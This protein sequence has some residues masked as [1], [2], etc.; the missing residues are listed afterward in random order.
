[1]VN[2]NSRATG[3]FVIKFAMSQFNIRLAVILTVAPEPGGGGQGQLPRSSLEAAW[4]PLFCLVSV[5]TEF[6]TEAELSEGKTV[7]SQFADK[8]SPKPDEL[9]KIKMRVG[10]GKA[11]REQKTFCSCMT[12]S[13]TKS[14][15]CQH[16]W[17]L[18]PTVSHPW[19]RLN[20]VK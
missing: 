16:S 17:L 4:E 1:M 3:K 13:T 20:S 18:T 6:Y 14:V 7:L 8:I 19:R 5:F 15:P 9:K 11:R 12:F 10:D 2:Q